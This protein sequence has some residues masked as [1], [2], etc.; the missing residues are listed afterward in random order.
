MHAQHI[1]IIVVGMALGF[2]ALAYYIRKALLHATANGYALGHQAGLTLQST[3]I[4]ALNLDLVRHRRKHQTEKSELMATLAEAQQKLNLQ[5]IQIQNLKASAFTIS[6]HA[7]L[8][9]IVQTL[10]LALQTWQPMVGTEPIQHRAKV[11][12]QQFVQLA[13][14]FIGTANTGQPGEAA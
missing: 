3:R 2:I 1:A 10:D 13:S 9:G 5:D 12:K 8:H 11:Q 6:D 14:R 4:E 7:L